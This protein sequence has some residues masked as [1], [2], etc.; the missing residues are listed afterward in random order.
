MDSIKHLFKFKKDD[1]AFLYAYL[2]AY[3][4][5]CSIYIPN[6]T[7][8]EEYPIV[9]LNVAPDYLVEFRNALKGSKLE[10]QEVS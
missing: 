3:E 6:P 7:P 8:G 5:M 10:Y 9:E 1:L 2:D 4:G